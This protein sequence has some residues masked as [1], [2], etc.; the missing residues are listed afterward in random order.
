L[1]RRKRLLES[2]RQ[3]ESRPHFIFAS[4]VT[5]FGSEPDLPLPAVIGD[6]TLPVPQSSYSIQKFI[7]Q[8]LVPTTRAEASSM[9]ESRGRSMARQAQRS[10]FELSFKHH[11]RTA[12]WGTGYLPGT[13]R[14]SVRTCFVSANDCGC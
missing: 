13:G 1:K 7:C 4:S 2:L 9:A 6:T 14:D 3:F 12:S 11:S 10:Y 8:Q 5:V